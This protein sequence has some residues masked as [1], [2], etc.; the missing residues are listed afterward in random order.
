MLNFDIDKYDEIFSVENCLNNRLHTKFKNVSGIYIIK[1]KTSKKEY[2]GST[3][4]FMARITEHLYY[5]QQN[6]HHSKKLQ[7][8]V[9]KY[10]FSDFEILFYKIDEDRDRLYDL[11]EALIIERDTFK[12]GYNQAINS[13]SFIKAE[14]TGTISKE[15]VLFIRNNIKNFTQ[16]ELAEMFGVTSKHISKIV[17]LN[18]WVGAEYIPENYKP[19]CKSKYSDEEIIEMRKLANKFS[20]QELAEKF[21]TTISFVYEI[22]HLL[23]YNRPNLI[24]EG[25]SI[26]DN[27]H[28]L[29]KEAALFI[30]EN[31]CKY[32]N[33]EFA[34]MFNCSKSA[35]ENVIVLARWVQPDTIPEG[36]K[37]PP[38]KLRNQKI[39]EF[40]ELNI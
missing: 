15:D 34:K 17:H 14:H 30:R 20:T 37:I 40:K 24:P 4:N 9:N 13:R 35:V 21:H 25:Y 28:K 23:R 6:K 18:E 38:R 12:N 39:K 7:N 19:G 33:A 36:Y 26:P 1:N 5:L 31:L 3:K 16:I 10:T 11:E 8:A 29:T 22:T 32:T 27:K 2:I